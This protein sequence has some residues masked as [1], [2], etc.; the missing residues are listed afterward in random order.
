M[1]L[2][3]KQGDVVVNGDE[4]YL[5]L[6]VL[7]GYWVQYGRSWFCVKKNPESV[8]RKTRATRYGFRKLKSV[9]DPIWLTGREVMERFINGSRLL[10]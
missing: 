5:S 1:T 6:G 2:S 10:G 9:E 3:L 8:G 4:V 7:N